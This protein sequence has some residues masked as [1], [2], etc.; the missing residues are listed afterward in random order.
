MA[1]KA[2]LGKGGKS[3]NWI[4][5]SKAKMVAKGTVGA[6]RKQSGVKKGQKIPKSRLRADV[7]KGGL[8]AKR[9]QWAI[10]INK[11]K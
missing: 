1:A 10:N 11:N 5:K 8:V 9:A 3:K 7:K 4:A 6:L 2:E